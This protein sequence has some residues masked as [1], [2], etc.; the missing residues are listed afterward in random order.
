MVGSFA[1]EG[2]HDIAEGS[3][4]SKGT[5]IVN[6]LQLAEGEKVTNM[7]CQSKDADNEGGFV[8]MVTK[9]PSL[10]A[11]FDWQIMLVTFSP[12]ASCS[13]LTMLVPLLVRLPSAMSC[14]PSEAKEP[15][16]LWRQPGLAAP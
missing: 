2:L 1:S 7:I 3:R 6:L 10:S 8:T 5:N 16:K 13:R 14:S 4:T 12:S 15:T 11:S 9:P